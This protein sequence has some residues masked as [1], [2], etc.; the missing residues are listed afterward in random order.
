MEAEIAEIHTFLVQYPPFDTLPEEA[1]KRVA[2][3][4]EVS[5]YR[6]GKTILNY[7]EQIDYLYIVRSGVVETYRRNGELHN[8]LDQGT[9]FGEMGLLMNNRVRFS[10]AAITDTL[11]YCLPG[12]LFTELCDTYEQFSDFVEVED[13]TRLRLAVTTT[14]MSNSLT[15]SKIKTLLHGEAVILSRH[16]TVQQAAQTMADMNVSAIL[17]NDPAEDGDEEPDRP[18]V[19]ILTDRDLCT[20]VLAPGVCSDTLI[21]EI[22]S[23]EL[24]SLDHNAYI[25]EAMLTMLRGNIRHLPILRDKQPIGIVDI[26]DIVRYESQSSLLLVNSIFAQ[27]SVGDLTALAQQVKNCFTRM[28]NEDAN[29]HMI[30]SAMSVIGRS[31][32]QRLTELAEEAYGP[33]PVPYCF[34][35]MGSMA[36]D[37]QLI[38]TDQ[39][40]AMILDESYQPDL[41]GRY[42]DALATFVCDGLAACGYDYCDGDIMATNSEWRKTLNGW[43]ECFADWIDNPDPQALLNSSIFFDLDGAAGLIKWA[44]QLKTFVVRRAR[45]NNRFLACLARNALNRTPPLGF[46]KNF[47]M[48]KDGRHN[49]S[50]NL[51]RRGTAPLADIARVHALAVGSRSQNSFDRLDDVIEAGILPKGRGADLREAM[52]YISVVRI[53]HQAFDID[54]GVEPDNNI[55]PDRM[56]DFERRNLKDAFQILSNAQN[57]LK[58]RYSAN[59]F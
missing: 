28:V 15:T 34:L 51:K 33:P 55:E 50:I 32:I 37:E 9:I 2:R 25:S 38:V 16:K 20:R 43:Q 35:T 54:T 30:G 27:T 29:S 41:H 52:E 57:F 26:I 46:F 7:G 22:M 6:A 56:S 13:S 58:F 21:G 47:V 59:R 24:F 14:N 18:F 44:E 48:E 19:G 53:R 4:L 49:N 23:T 11:V 31:F 45:K 17:I 12:T 5:Y 40:N 39:D 8:R 10:A 42:F 36:R 1:V 3:H